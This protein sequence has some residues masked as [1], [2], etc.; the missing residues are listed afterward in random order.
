MLSRTNC[1]FSRMN[2]LA[3]AYLSFGEP[4]ILV[5]NMISD[6]VKGAQKSLYAASVQKGIVL[7]RAIDAFTDDHPVTAR[8]KQV[9][10]PAYRLY[11]GPIMDIVYDHFLATDETEFSDASLLR[12]TGDVYQTLEEET[13]HLPQAFLPAFTYMRMENWLYHYRTLNGI[14]KSLRGLIRR[15]AFISDSATAIA[16]L[17]EHYDDLNNCY[18]DFFP[19]VKQFAKQKLGEILA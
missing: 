4:Q 16:L 8:A 19:A 14:E 15:A 11:S 9:F 12:F 17:H 2:Y 13:V 7:H 18:R 3:H 6:F 1:T 5:G 10:R